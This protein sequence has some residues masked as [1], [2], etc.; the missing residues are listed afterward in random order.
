MTSPGSDS[1]IRRL[2]EAS[3]LGTP[4]ARKLR[5][6]VPDDTAQRIVER[7][8]ALSTRDCVVNVKN[9]GAVGDGITDDAPAIQAAIDAAATPCE[10]WFCPTS[11]ETECGVHGGF[12]VCCNR[13]DLHRPVEPGAC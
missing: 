9:F 6:S 1:P 11:G 10:M 3:S 4:D 13:P 2:I 12:D 5:D 7:A 8:A